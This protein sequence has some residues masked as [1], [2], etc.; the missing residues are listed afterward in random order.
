[1]ADLVNLSSYGSYWFIPDDGIYAFAYFPSRKGTKERLTIEEAFADKGIFACFRNGTAGGGF[2]GFC[3]KAEERLPSME[4]IADGERSYVWV[5]DSGEDW[6]CHFLKEK[7]GLVSGEIFYDMGGYLFN[8][9]VSGCRCSVSLEGG[10]AHFSVPLSGKLRP[11]CT[12]RF[13]TLGILGVNLSG[14]A[15][16]GSLLASV[17]CAGEGEHMKNLGVGQNFVYDGG[18]IGTNAGGTGSCLISQL[19]LEETQD[20]F[21]LE[22]RLHPFRPLLAQASFLRV[23]GASQTMLA[24]CFSFADGFPLGL[25]TSGLTLVFHRFPAREGQSLYLSPGGKC[26]AGRMG[27]QEGSSCFLH[28]PCSP[29]DLSLFCGLDG[30]QSLSLKEEGLNL[31]FVKKPSYFL[32]AKGD[33]QV[34][35]L[36]GCTAPWIA[37]EQ[38]PEVNP[39][40]YRHPPGQYAWE[41]GE[42][43]GVFTAYPERELLFSSPEGCAL[44]VLARRMRLPSPAE[45]GEKEYAALIRGEA[46]K[47]GWFDAQVLAPVRGLVMKQTG[48]TPQARGRKPRS[49]KLCVAGGYAY[50]LAEGEKELSWL[51]FD[52]SGEGGAGDIP[53]LA[54]THVKGEMKE[55]FL[56][57]EAFLVLADTGALSECCSYP[58]RMT[59]ENMGRVLGH[60][61]I[62]EGNKEELKA[63]FDKN[64][65]LYHYQFPDEASL[66]AVLLQA[67]PS[68]HEEQVRII[69]GIC[70][71]LVVKQGGFRFSLAPRNWDRGEGTILLCKFRKG[72]SAEELVQDPASWAFPAAAGDGAETGKK[73]LRLLDY[74][75]REAEE[76]GGNGHQTEYAEFLALMREPDFIGII[77]LNC[78]CINRELPE[79]L[80]GYGLESSSGELYAV[81]I[82]LAVSLAGQREDGG[83]RFHTKTEIMLDYRLQQES[84]VFSPERLFLL[85]REGEAVWQRIHASFAVSSLFGEEAAL[86]GNGNTIMLCGTMAVRGGVS[87]YDF[88]P[89]TEA[90][91]FLQNSAL[92]SVELGRISMTKTRGMEADQLIFTI[93]GRLRFRET[94]GFDGYGY[95]R[96]GNVDGYLG[97]TGL[98]YRVGVS[99]R[100][101]AASGVWDMGGIRVSA[102]DI[103]RQG[104]F[105]DCFP[106]RLKGIY[107]YGN[108]AATPAS[109]GFTG[110]QAPVG[111][112]ELGESWYGLVWETDLGAA[113]LDAL[114]GISLRILFAWGRAPQEE[115]ASLAALS[116]RL[117]QYVGM[118]LVT[119]GGKLYAMEFTVFDACKLSFKNIELTYSRPLGG[120]AVYSIQ[121]RNFALKLLGLSLPGGYNTLG[122][123]ANPEKE[124]K[125][126]LGWYCAYGKGS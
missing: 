30:G 54:F 76:D 117:S 10:Q 15:E 107:C 12:R 82:R 84:P 112:G 113:G 49:G 44:P 3:Q 31:H 116:D 40:V 9:Y 99:H 58:L 26:P 41:A 18:A 56:E 83:I 89:L 88:S 125:E 93:R 118:Q 33:G 27:P 96:S 55:A 120:R 102:R 94:D 114:R 70:G 52:D 8:V 110:I 17:P 92:L 87:L 86:T 32:S 25:R 121:F 51:G 75:K 35:L 4:G 65:S 61:E 123:Y 39:E 63:F 22:G 36:E 124:G 47:A 37:V 71:E 78:P 126:Q 66:E 72:A 14:S 69:E 67:S 95:G 7:D 11:P 81:Y 98:V 103:P 2:R 64:K 111:Q 97:F 19:I 45:G 59:E 6:I 34:Q 74:A 48:I 1:M 108:G 21:C 57:R 91:Y 106:A 90:E 68:L 50:M 43:P 73:I 24:S 46:E 62:P 122:I 28:D 29:N 77:A 85:L 115:N 20:A 100:T 79:G 16:A 42:D 109:L 104:S 5:D 105:A 80:T 23:T 119:A 38:A 13:Y 101:G 60:G 53:S